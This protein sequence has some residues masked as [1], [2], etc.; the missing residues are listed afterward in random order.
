LPNGNGAATGGGATNAGVVTG[1]LGGGAMTAAPGGTG[2]GTTPSG[3]IIA[4]GG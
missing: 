1:E 3:A 4:G 2:A